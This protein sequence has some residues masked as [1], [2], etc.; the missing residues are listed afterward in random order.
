MMRL[1]TPGYLH[2]CLVFIVALHPIGMES[3]FGQQASRTQP[4]IAALVHHLESGSSA[5]KLDA[6]TRLGHLGPYASHAVSGLARALTSGD[7]ALKYEVLVALGHIGPL[8]TESI[9]EV[10]VVLSSDILPLRAAALD[11]LRRIGTVP[12]AVAEEVEELATDSTE[13]V[14]TAAVRCLVTMEREDSAAVAAAVPGLVKAL[15]NQRPSVRNA[16]ANALVE[17]GESVVPSLRNPLGSDQ[18]VVR[19]KSCEVAGRLGD[20]AAGLVPLLVARL[21]DEDKLVVRSAASAL[22]EVRSEPELV[23]PRLQQLLADDSASVRAVA[24]SALAEFGPL[25]G[26]TIPA[27]CR[28][29][30]DDSTIVRAAAARALGQIGEGSE[31]SVHAL[32]DAVDDAHGGVTIQAANSLSQLGAAAVP[33]LIRLLDKPHYRDLAVTVLGEIGPAA[34]TAVP[35]LVALL[36]SDNEQLRRESFIALA[37]IGPEA[38]AAVPALL[39]ILKDP[40]AG[41]SR[42]GAAYVLGHIGEQASVPVL[43]KI[44]SGAGDTDAQVLRASAWALVMLRPDDS[45]N[46]PIVLPYLTEALS[47]EIP[48][49]RK[50]ALAAIGQLGAGGQPASDALME[51]ARNDQ[52]TTVRSEALHALA[53]L[54]KISDEVMPIAI[55]AMDDH[56]PHVRNSARFLLGKMGARASVAAAK[57]KIGTREGA[58]MDRIVA[59][60]ALARVAPSDEHNRLAVPFMLQA[61]PDPNPRVRAEAAHTLGII[62]I[63]RPEVVDALKTAAS[64]QDKNVASAAKTALEQLK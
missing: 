60:W 34:K 22:G 46:A 30:N 5:E 8:A 59:A 33:A 48:L 18:A 2:A 27:V 53:L 14:M 9:D 16:A 50:E 44:L 49:A 64:D 10:A 40:Q 1:C 57:L 11:T 56:D 42:G 58:V 23:L 47:S 41:A 3:L 4:A 52:E 6:A 20:A 29:I 51:L 36:K 63:S 19:R 38:T 26:K 32:M 55:V 25:A 37:T 24:L 21:S 17:I 45:A 43:K 15:S 13:A 54:P 39:K 28:M 61:L 12:P 62:G 35:A 7:P 31:E